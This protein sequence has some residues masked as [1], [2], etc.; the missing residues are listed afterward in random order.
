MLP[1]LKQAQGQALERRLKATQDKLDE[2]SEALAACLEEKAKQ[3]PS[4]TSVSQEV[5]NDCVQKS[6]TARQI[7]EEAQSELKQLQTE[8]KT[9]QKQAA[10]DVAACQKDVAGVDVSA[11]YVCNWLHTDVVQ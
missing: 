7:A 8:L 6:Q 5:Y 3:A 2:T 11:L 10:K 4:K 1:L 9:V